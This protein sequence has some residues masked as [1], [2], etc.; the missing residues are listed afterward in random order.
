MVDGGKGQLSIAL[1]VLQKIELTTV[2][3]IGLA[4]RLEEVFLP[5]QNE[6]VQLPRT[7]SG[8]RLMQQIRDEAHRFAVT[9]HRSVRTK[10][11]IQSE[12]DM[13]QGVG[14]KRAK[15]LLETFNSIQGVRAATEE[16]LITIVGKTTARNILKYFNDSKSSTSAG[17]V[18]H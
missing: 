5:N 13:I 18:H 4:K 11:I 16:Q 1:E 3:I 8:L 7:S 17:A 10:R 6:P 15:E 2:P 9:F 12:L 14:K